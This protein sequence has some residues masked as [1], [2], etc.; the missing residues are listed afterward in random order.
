MSVALGFRAHTGWAAVVALRGPSASPEVIERRRL[1][2]VEEGLPVAVFHAA[3]S[4]DLTLEGAEE[5]VRRATDS[6]TRMAERAIGELVRELGDV[7]CVGVVLGSGRASTNVKRAISSH[8]GKHAA[9]G[10]LAR[11]VLIDASSSLGLQVVGV[12][13]GELHGRGSSVL[14]L[15]PDELRARIVELRRTIGPPWTKDQKHAALV[16]WIALAPSTG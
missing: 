3:G 11:Q 9:E 4:S 2:F 15:P 12:R 13:E 1:G 10:E 8:A 14:G 7:T 5:L 6:M 16:A